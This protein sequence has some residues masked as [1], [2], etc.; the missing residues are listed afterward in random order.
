MKILDYGLSFIHGKAPGN[1]VRFW[2]ESVT[3]IIDE[4]NNR[5]EDFYQCGACKSE[6]TFAEHDLFVKGN[7]DFL[8]IFGPKDSVVF[9]RHARFTGG[10]RQIQPSEKWWDGQVYNLMEARG[11]RDL[12][13]TEAIRKA[14]HEALPLVACTEIWNEETKMRAVIQCPVKTMNILDDRDLYQV[15]TGPVAWPDLTR[16]YDRLVDSISLAFVAFNAPQFAD[17]VIEAPTPILENGKEVGK[18][19]HYSQ[20]VSHTAKNV[21]YATARG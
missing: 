18:V 3:R 12:K 16:P 8:P 5:T 14:T 1:R 21:L 4:R 19:F 9:R 13:D 17:F 15:D 7:Y 11:V 20:I 2:V 6:N 10:Y